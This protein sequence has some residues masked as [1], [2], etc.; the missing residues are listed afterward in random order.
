MALYAREQRL[1]AWNSREKNGTIS[2]LVANASKQQDGSYDNDFR[3][4]AYV[5]KK[6]APVFDGITLPTQDNGVCL[7]FTADVIHTV[8]WDKENKKEIVFYRLT[9]VK[10]DDVT[11]ASTT[12]EAEDDPF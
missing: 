5:T 1:K 4:W 3:A 9:N 2:L 6:S 11:V 7:R 10:L 8:K 12:D